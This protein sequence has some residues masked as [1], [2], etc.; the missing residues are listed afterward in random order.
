MGVLRQA[1][2]LEGKSH[3]EDLREENVHDRLDDTVDIVTL[4]TSELQKTLQDTK[5]KN[6]DL[7]GSLSAAKKL[8]RALRKPR[9]LETKLST[10]T[11]NLTFLNEDQKSEHAL[12]LM[13]EYV[14]GGKHLT[15][16]SLEIFNLVSCCEEIFKAFSEEEDICL[17]KSPMKTVRRIIEQSVPVPRVACSKNPDIM[18]R[19]FERFFVMR[20]RIYLHWLS[21]PEES[22]D[23]YS[24]KTVA[25]TNLQ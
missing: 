4:H 19:L 15:Y 7:E 25:D 14:Q 3:L 9:Q 6:C 22:D 11:R 10:L 16:V 1:R 13:K 24:S 21:L 12:V 20:L 8:K 23:G 5:R 2:T 17:L 18:R